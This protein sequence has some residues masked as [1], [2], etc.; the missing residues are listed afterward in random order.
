MGCD[1]WTVN[2]GGYFDQYGPISQAW[3]G[4]GPPEELVS[5]LETWTEYPHFDRNMTSCWTHGEPTFVEILRRVLRLNE[6]IERDE[7]DD[8]QRSR[9]RDRHSFLDAQNQGFKSN[10][11]VGGWRHSGLYL[12]SDHGSET[13][14]YF[15]DA[16]KWAVWEACQKAENGVCSIYTK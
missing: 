1:N 7:A 6:G 8:G 11:I 15:Y 13:T 12:R 3:T 4:L 14:L 2:T 10:I 9:T 16:V 5:Y